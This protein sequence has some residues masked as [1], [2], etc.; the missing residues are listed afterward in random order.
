MRLYKSLSRSVGL[1]VGLSV[2]WL[3]PRLLFWRLL[4]RA[5][6]F[7][8]LF[9]SIQCGT[10]KKQRYKTLYISAFMHPIISFYMTN[11]KSMKSGVDCRKPY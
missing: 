7:G 5:K 3:V 11:G 10:K 8:H 6:V 2:G 1:S 4:P 9:M